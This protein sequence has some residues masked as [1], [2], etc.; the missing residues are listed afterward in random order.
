MR[1]PHKH[2][3]SA[4]K[5]TLKRTRI[6][7]FFE[8]LPFLRSCRASSLSSSF[9]GTAINAV[10]NRRKFSSIGSR[11]AVFRVAG[12]MFQPFFFLPRFGAPRRGVTSVARFIPRRLFASQ[13]LESQTLAHDVTRSLDE[14]FRVLNLAVIESESLLVKVAEKMKWLYRNISST[15][16]SLEQT[17]KV[18]NS[19]GVNDS[20][21]VPLGMIDHFVGVILIKLS[22]RAKRIAVNS[23]ASLDVFGHLAVERLALGVWHNH[24]PNLAMTRQQAHNRNLAGGLVSS[25]KRSC[26]FSHT[27]SQCRTVHVPRLAA[28]ESFVNF[29]LAAKLGEGS[30]LHSL[31]YSVKQ[32][33]C[34]LLSNAEGAVNLVG[35][36]AVL[37]VHY[38][39]DSRQPL[40]Q[41]D[42][43]IFHDGAKLDAEVLFAALA[44]PDATGFN[45]RVPVVTTARASDNAIRPT[46]RNH[47][48]ER[49]IRV[50]K[51]DDCS[52]ESLW[53]CVVVLHGRSIV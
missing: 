46:D 25:S 14:A 21:N 42:R 22:I 41:T 53:K 52:L 43:A 1:K 18:F 16:G 17:P 50:G 24:S 12:F 31:A 6:S 11:L 29:D 19:V 49:G 33:P 26:K 3:T 13:L 51:V 9:L 38:Q 36:N 32:E 39:H 44:Y 45:K 48:T 37:R 27:P 8:R 34:A 23:R 47:A 5:E 4:L 20:V 40:I 7:H 2:W 30:G 28:D 15:E 10:A 35:T